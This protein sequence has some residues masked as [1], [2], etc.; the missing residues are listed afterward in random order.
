MDVSKNKTFRWGY[1]SFS[2]PSGSISVCS[3]NAV[4]DGS[5]NLLEML[6]L[7]LCFVQLSVVQ[8]R[9]PNITESNTLIMVASISLTADF[10]IYFSLVHPAL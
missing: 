9:A 6:L 4:F 10:V 7:L 2:R 3:E 8:G 5:S 1:V